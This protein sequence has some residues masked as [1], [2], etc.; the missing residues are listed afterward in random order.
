MLGFE[1]RPTTSVGIAKTRC[2]RNN[3]GEHTSLT[4]CC[5]VLWSKCYAVELSNWRPL[6]YLWYQ[7]TSSASWRQHPHDAAS[8]WIKKFET[9][10]HRVWVGQLKCFL[11]C[12]CGHFF[13]WFGILGWIRIIL[14]EKGVWREGVFDRVF[15]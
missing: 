13:G 11:I 4:R 15:N 7:R 9:G 12:V 3:A 14:K 2:Q 5:D 10:F 1:I 6:V 8:L